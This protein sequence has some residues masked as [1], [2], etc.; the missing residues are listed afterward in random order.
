MDWREMAGRSTLTSPSSTPSSLLDSAATWSWITS[1]KKKD[2]FWFLGHGDIDAHVDPENINKASP[3]HDSMYHL[4]GWRLSLQHS[5]Q[6]DV[7][8]VHHPESTESIET[9]TESNV[10][11]KERKRTRGAHAVPR[12][13]QEDKGGQLANPSIKDPLR[14]WVISIGWLIASGVDIY[15]IYTLIRRPTM[16]LDFSLTLILNH[17]IL[18]TYYASSFPT[19]LFFW[20]IMSIGTLFLIVF[21]EQLCV[22]R[23]LRQGLKTIRATSSSTSPST[24]TS[25]SAAPGAGAYGG[26]RTPLLSSMMVPGR[27]RTIFGPSQEE[28]FNANLERMGHDDGVGDDDDDDDFNLDIDDDQ[29]HGHG[30]Q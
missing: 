22:R 19:S 13:D 2:T 29:Q 28:L 26:N 17:T 1:T 14:G 23:E 7:E 10:D 20:F 27:R 8:T 18:T 9:K 5:P 16:V 15:I 12:N 25:T 3:R 11:S 4:G 6:V 30:H 24:F 21:A